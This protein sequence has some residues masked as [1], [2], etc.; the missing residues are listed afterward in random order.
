MFK[1]IDLSDRF[2]GSVHDKLETPSEYEFISSKTISKNS[3][4]NNMIEDLATKIGLKDQLL[5]SSF[6]QLQAGDYLQWSDIDI[7]NNDTI[8]KFFTIALT[9]KNFIEFKDG[10]VKVP[11]GSAIEFNTGDKH[12]IQNVDSKQTWLVLMV[13]DHLDISAL[14]KN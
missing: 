1:R 8:G 7:W 13:P 14:L 6:L 9:G 11:K 4:L 12:R 5:V 10:I 3:K 2:N